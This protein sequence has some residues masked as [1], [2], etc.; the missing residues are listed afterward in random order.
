[1]HLTLYYAP[2]AC[3]LVPYVLLEE[4]HADFDIC[5]VNMKNA[6]HMSA[7]FLKLNPKHKV[8]VL[9][10]NK[11]PLTENIAIQLW[12]ADHY[13]EANLL[14]NNA[15]EKYKAIALLS[16]CASGIHPS[17]T[18]QFKPHAYCDLPDTEANVK[19]CALKILMANFQIAD[20]LL[21]NRDW[22]FDSFSAPDAYFFWCFRRAIL[23]DIDI[24][25]FTHCLAHYK[26]M[27]MRTSVKKVLQYEADILAEFAKTF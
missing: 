18:P 15:L 4:A 5:P 1:M 2:V 26:R 22:F 13:P 7:E 8:P 20:E 23:F 11:E 19:Q 3:S 14:P 27:L 16:W 10:I 9:V 24:S 6:Q 17:L 21:A 25:K 12:I